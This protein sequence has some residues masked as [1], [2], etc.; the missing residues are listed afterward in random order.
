MDPY[1]R[2]EAL[3]QMGAPLEAQVMA[4]M[5]AWEGGRLQREGAVSAYLS[6][7][8]RAAREERDPYT[9]PP[10]IAALLA[11]DARLPAQ[12]R[13]TDAE[14]FSGEGEPQPAEKT[15]TGP[16]VSWTVE[17]TT[18][19][20]VSSLPFA[21]AV[22]VADDPMKWG[23]ASFQIQCVN[24]LPM[25]PNGALWRRRLTK[26]TTPGRPLKTDMRT[27]ETI[28]I[29]ATGDDDANGSGHRRYDYRLVAAE[30]LPNYQAL[31]EDSGWIELRGDSTGTLIRIKKRVTASRP[32]DDPF[33]AILAA[34]F[35]A[36]LWLWAS[37]F[38]QATD[39]PS[40]S[41]QALKSPPL[42]AAPQKKLTQDRS[43]DVAVLGAG[44]A[45]LACAWLLSNPSDRQGQ[46]AWH[47]EDQAA[48]KVNVTLL[49]RQSRPGG[50]AASGRRVDSERFRVEEHGLHV[51]MGF[52]ANV[53]KV[54]EWAGATDTL[55]DVSTTLIPESRGTDLEAGWRLNFMAWRKRADTGTLTD[56]LKSRGDFWTS[57]HRALLF[58]PAASASRPF[59]RAFV[60][61]GR[62]LGVLY[63]ESTPSADGRDMNTLMLRWL[64]E[65]V[66]TVEIN[67]A[68][69]HEPADWKLSAAA[70]SSPGEIVALSKLLRKFAR[71]C[72][73]ANDPRPGV[74]R[75]REALELATTIAI[76]L[77]QVGLFPRWAIDQPN[78]LLTQRYGAWARAVQTQDSESLK[79]WLERCGCEPGFVDGSLLLTSV[80]AG[81]FTTPQGIAAGTFINGLARLLFTYDSAPFKR[82][83]GGTGEVVIGPLYAALLA[84]THVTV[85]LGTEVRAVERKGKR[86]VA[87]RIAQKRTPEPYDFGLWGPAGR[88]GWRI[89][90]RDKEVLAPAEERLR[91][92][93]FVL[94]IPP[95]GKRL[96]GLP[97]ALADDLADIKSTATI[98]LQHW[99]RGEPRYKGVI[100]SGLDGPLRCAA[101]MEQLKEGSGYTHAAVY[102]C[103]DVDDDTA[104]KWRKDR[105]ERDAWLAANAA[106]LQEG[107]ALAEPHLSVNDCG[108]ERYVCADSKT[109][110]A[111][112]L[113]YETGL[114][115]LWLAGDWTRSALS[116]GSIEAA[117]TSGLEAARHL[118]ETHGCVVNFP[119]VGSIL[120]KEGS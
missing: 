36:Q 53:F 10:D 100:V 2:A 33:R 66:I 27:K 65:R 40:N 52:Y 29:T 120:E 25:P 47:H 20:L 16:L 72:L 14:A 5:E 56:F 105:R 114:D 88:S 71:K 87:A 110:A 78:D 86:I 69:W 42:P 75:L 55:E 95:F 17:A 79:E 77:D 6:F 109:Q 90:L 116:C 107:E 83:L 58:E 64:V 51:L 7:A 113:V 32:A 9:L 23:D 21:R 59:L 13:L 96:P 93:A 61:I 63:P 106:R 18:P 3:V 84:K 15:P 119:I 117:F 8:Q 89:P 73:S 112:R 91:A 76:G 38:V 101:S 43:L 12:L 30:G 102:A 82:M 46:V 62:Q 26:I 39:G 24:V 118:L 49:D 111:R 28:E 97:E 98:G 67:A 74:R 81:L 4:L 44:P 92:D 70:S 34:G 80:T 1:E 103:G 31:S 48:F 54:L 57:G 85:R 11:I 94:A 22:A 99:T 68:F 50:K 37:S 35:S 60:E 41:S 19:S 45:G 104:Q 108:S 115:N